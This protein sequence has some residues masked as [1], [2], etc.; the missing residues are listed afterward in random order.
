[1]HTRQQETTQRYDDLIRRM[2]ATLGREAAAEMCRRNLWYGL[3]ERILAT[4]ALAA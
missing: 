2:I 4:P 1:M 3:A